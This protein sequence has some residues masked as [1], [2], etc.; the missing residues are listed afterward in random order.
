MV[1]NEEE[2][3]GF[4]SQLV[5]YKLRLTDQKDFLVQKKTSH[6]FIMKTANFHDLA[7]RATLKESA[8]ASSLIF[9]FNDRAL[10]F[11]SR[12]LELLKNLKKRVHDIF[13]STVLFE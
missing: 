2:K 4:D 9:L 7:D 6:R 12:T 11:D 3:R 1:W 10:V 5:L 8:D 13:G